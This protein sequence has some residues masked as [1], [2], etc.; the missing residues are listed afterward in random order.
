MLIIAFHET[1]AP[2]GKATGK[3][4]LAAI[5][6]EGVGGRSGDEVA[7]TFIAALRHPCF[8]DCDQFTFWL[9]NCTGQN[10]IWILS[11]ALANE[12]MNKE[13]GINT[14]NLKFFTKGHTF[15]SADSFHA[16]VEK[17]MRHPYQETQKWM[18]VYNF[19]DFVEVIKAVCAVPLVMQPANFF[20][21]QNGNPPL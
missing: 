15:M 7:S 10:K 20:E 6:H 2:V 5:W 19:Q 9:D 17:K 4:I 18:G 12:M 11:G 3:P 14:V 13:S 21:Y 16:K 1:F 8:S